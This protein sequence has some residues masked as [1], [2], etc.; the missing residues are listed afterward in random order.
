MTKH[1]PH[2]AFFG[3]P[4]I[5]VLVLDELLK[6]D[7]VPDLVVSN[8]DAPVGRPRALTPPPVAR[9]AR[10]HDVE[11]FQ[12]ESLRDSGS[13]SPLTKNTWD[14]FVVVAYG[15]I[16][17]A[18]LLK[19]PKHGVLNMHPSL[20]PLL[21]GASPVRS[22]ILEDRRQTGVTIML[23]DEKVDHGPI[24]AQEVVT[25]HEDEWPID[26]RELEERLAKIGGRL[27]AETIPEWLKGNIDPQEQN[28]ADATECVKLTK[29]MGRLEI[30]LRNLPKGSDA[31]RALLKIRAL[32]GWPET[33]FIHE[34]KRIKVKD[35]ELDAAGVLQ[36]LTVVPEGK[37]EM[38]FAEYLK[39]LS[40][41][42]QTDK[43][44]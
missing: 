38:P 4:D 2:I 31:Y 15:K 21:R 8:P 12:P 24:L 37:K 10:E 26:G 39:T 9:W 41:K 40:H 11:L 16:L 5:A 14:L 1:K 33:Y 18:W 29:E 22:A 20:L 28:Q 30:D 44:S 6:S 42:Q 17:P 13:L 43:R 35:A 36:I 23:M 7:M 34:G 3:T 32:A 25:I 19:L 27:L